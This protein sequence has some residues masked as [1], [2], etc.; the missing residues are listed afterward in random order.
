MQGVEDRAAFCGFSEKFALALSPC[1]QFSFL[2]KH[3]NYV[4]T[5]LQKVYGISWLYFKEI[6]RK[7][8]VSHSYALNVSTWGIG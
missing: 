4:V 6:C 8:G 5:T 1:T 7:F 3:E 2:H